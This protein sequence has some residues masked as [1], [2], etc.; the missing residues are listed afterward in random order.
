MT[1]STGAP[2]PEVF[3]VGTGRCGST[4][5]SNILN[6]HPD[7]L[8]LSELFMELA[9]RAFIHERLSGRQFWKL[10]SQASS[11]VRRTLNPRW[12]P[13]EFLYRFGPQARFRPGTLPPICYIT[14][15][16]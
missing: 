8:S 11:T 4:L 6:T 13:D 9:T 7:I 5:I 16:H 14:L 3:V 1:A 2:F 15:P 12:C 10:L